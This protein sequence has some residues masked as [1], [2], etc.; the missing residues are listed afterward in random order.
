MIWI[1]ITL[2]ISAIVY[3]GFVLMYQYAVMWAIL[4]ILLLVSLVILHLDAKRH[5]FKLSS[6]AGIIA[7]PFVATLG[8]GVRIGTA[9]ASSQGALLLITY[10]L[11]GVVIYAALYATLRFSSRDPIDLNKSA[12]SEEPK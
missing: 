8:A 7:V 10:L 5:L 3:C 2:T 11:V 1:S 9:I 6:I 4:P 12:S